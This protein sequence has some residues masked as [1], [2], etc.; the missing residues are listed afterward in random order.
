M[1][2]TILL[3]AF[4]LFTLSMAAQSWES[5]KSNSETYYFGEGWGNSIDEADNNALAALVSKISVN[6]TAGSKNSDRSTIT[7]GALDEVSQF[8][9]TVSTY[10]QAS[11]NNT[12]RVIIKN[13]PDAHVGRWIK[14]SEV[15]KI[16]ASR[17]FKIKD[18]IK[19]AQMAEEKGKADDALRN[20]YWALTLLK[21]LQLPD[22]VCYVDAQKAG[23]RALTRW[24]PERMNNVFEQLDAKVVKRTGDVVELFITYKGK[25]V[26]SIDYTYFDGQGWGSIYSAKD[27]RGVLELAPGNTSTNYQL[28]Y[29]FEYRGQAHIDR[30]LESVLKVV[31]STQMRD[32]YVTIGSQVAAAPAVDK[33]TASFSN[34]AAAI[35]KAPETLPQTADYTA[36]IE[37]VLS[38]VRSRNYNAPKEC[39][40]T[41]GWDIY[42]R[43]VHYGTARVVGTPDLKF[44]RNGNYV[45]GRGVQMS[46][47]FKTGLRKSFV[48]DVV[49]N[50]DSTGKIDYMSFGLG[51]TA[52]DDIL[53]KGVWS[54]QARLAIMNFLENYKTAYGLERLDYIRSLFDDNAV[55]IVG[56][57]VRNATLTRNRETGRGT[58]S[59]NNV[60][61]TN[62]Y[63][64]DQYLTNLE[65]CFGQNEYINIRFGNN[66]VVKL[67]NGGELYA[68]Q[69]AQD[70][71]STTYGD[72][73]YLFLMVDINDPENPIIKVRTWQPEKDPNFGL[74]GPED[75]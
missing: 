57:V 34:T 33:A 52:A 4:S 15:Y 16:F 41:E 7:N 32:A 62:R 1:R 53:N 18:M 69:L 49:F 22:T 13:E 3:T 42:Q 38:A 21:S 74:Y 60:I 70:Y 29:E 51:D 72:K 73:G 2:K 20:Y 8:S 66:D 35:K 43:M 40:T 44:Y 71:Y 54:Q 23:H 10:S 46:F 12:S 14:K 63:T 75:F 50:F 65:R 68:I 30:E 55:I 61:K 9:S 27:G 56:N 25:P 31:K 48:E 11:L 6:V 67:A 17:I 24:I 19:S 5:V 58:I 45:V 59:Y 26:N 28:K 64:K 39:F 47:S 36:K 37:Q